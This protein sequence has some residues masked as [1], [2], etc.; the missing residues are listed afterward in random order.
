MRYTVFVKFK[1]NGKISVNG[2]E[3]TIFLRSRP[4]KGKA[5]KELIYKVAKYF[6]IS[7]SKVH[8]ISGATSSKKVIEIQETN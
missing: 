5:N 8:I 7:T 1:P 6:A 2:N 3:I 4:E